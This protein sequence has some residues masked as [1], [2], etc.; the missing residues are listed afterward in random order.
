MSLRRS[1]EKRRKDGRWIAVGLVVLLVL[2]SG[3]YYLLLSSRELPEEL[4][5]NRLLFFVLSY[6]NG[7][8][9]L[10]I[11]FVLARNLFKLAV[12]RRHRLLGSKLKTKLVLTYVG[13]SLI[14]V[15]LLFVYGSGLLRGWMDRW[16]DEPAIERGPRTRAFAVARGVQRS[17]SDRRL[18]SAMPERTLRRIRDIEGSPTSRKR[19]RRRSSLDSAVSPPSSSATRDRRPGRSYNG[20]DFV[21]ARGQFSDHPSDGLPDLG[22]PSS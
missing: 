13:L 3:L 22:S 2:L 14:P 12:E 15:V 11:F 19:S 5:T 6:L 16:F 9:I 21:H 10:A 4:L 7:V 17:S 1:F 18:G 8:L 20:T